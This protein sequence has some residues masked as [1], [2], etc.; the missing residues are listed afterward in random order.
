MFVPVSASLKRIRNLMGEAINCF[1][2]W[3]I[4][5]HR[6][7]LKLRMEKPCNFTEL[8]TMV[9]KL[10]HLVSILNHTRIII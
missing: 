10:S 9:H 2:S 7:A 4:T 8:Q 1:P 3:I 5:L 6:I